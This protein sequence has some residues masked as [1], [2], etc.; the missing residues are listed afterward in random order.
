MKRVIIDKKTDEDK[1]KE[2]LG[3]MIEGT[4]EHPLAKE[5][6][7]GILANIIAL[8]RKF[9]NPER[10]KRN[11]A[12]EPED[13]YEHVEVYFRTVLR[14]KWI[15]IRPSHGLNATTVFVD[16][17]YVHID[18]DQTERERIYIKPYYHIEMPDLRLFQTLK[19]EHKRFFEQAFTEQSSVLNKLVKEVMNKGLEVILSDGRKTLMF[20]NTNPTGKLVSKNMKE[21]M[22][23]FL[24]DCRE[25]T[26]LWHSYDENVLFRRFPG[27]TTIP[28]VYD[29][30][31]LSRIFASDRGEIEPVVSENL[32]KTAVF[33]I[34]DE[35]SKVRFNFWFKPSNDPTTIHYKTEIENP[36][37]V[38]MEEIAG[39][40]EK[41]G[42][43]IEYLQRQ[44]SVLPSERFIPWEEHDGKRKREEEIIGKLEVCVFSPVLSKTV[45]RDSLNVAH[46]DLRE[47][48]EV[49][50]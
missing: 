28:D 50:P 1:V 27:D 23:G 30:S 13:M 5:L 43:E 34:R 20:P 40:F 37:G 36:A 12:Y 9:F 19:R 7:E 49:S 42:N 41:F 39:I 31:F 18:D 14:G 29:L 3:K 4:F 6:L 8:D 25:V 33:F 45:L 44:I 26:V 32:E 17:P 24:K 10:L 48:I 46:E 47:S 38:P 15:W 22:K 21:T 2:Q 11:Y 35:E 16:G